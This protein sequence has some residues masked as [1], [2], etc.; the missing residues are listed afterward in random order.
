MTHL[1]IQQ[2]F[3]LMITGFVVAMTASFLFAWNA[4][5]PLQTQWSHYL[6]HVAKREDLLME[7]R[8]A[9]GYGGLIH[10]FKNYVLRA[11]EKYAQRAREHAGELRRLIKEYRALGDVSAQ[12]EAALNDLIAVMTAYIDQLGSIEKMVAEGQ[13]A[14]TIDKTVKVDD[15]PAFHAFDVLHQRYVALTEEGTHHVNESVNHI[16]V[17]LAWVLVPSGLMGVLIMLW[18]SRSIRTPLAQF[19]G[20]IEQVRETH[21]VSLRVN[22]STQDE[23]GRASDAFDHMLGEFG[24]IVDQVKHSA[25]GLAADIE[26]FSST[27]DDTRRAMDTQKQETEQIA[28]AMN[29]MA[30]TVQEVA[31]NA[32]TAAQAATDANEAS[33][34]G[35]NEVQQTVSTI[36][37]LAAGIA[38]AAAVIHRL[39]DDSEAIGGV[40]DVIKGIAEQTN[41]LALNAA[42][43]AARAGEQGRGFAVVA[44]EVRTLAQRTQESTAE[45]QGMIERLQ[46]GASEA[47]AVMSTSRDQAEASVT[48]ANNAGTAL[49]A[50][51]ES[52]SNISNMNAQ[53]ATA[54][55]EQSVVAEEMNQNVVRISHASEQ[56]AGSAALTADAAQRMVGEVETLTAS[57]SR[58]QTGGQQVDLEA[59]KARH[60]AWKTKMRSFLDGKSSMTA[61]QAM[62]HRDC[63]LGQWYYSAGIANYGDLKE[64]QDLEKPHEELHQVVK[65]IVQLKNTGDQVAAEREY[66]NI[67]PLSDRIVGLLEGIE[68]KLS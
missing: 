28:T 31:R 25:N 30:A 34:R 21:D 58:F 7:I 66:Q 53:I 20:V 26:Q 61:E 35:N 45:I 11:E 55:E 10:N 41:L 39:E 40:L 43:E 59:A 68:R 65:K 17:I 46:S 23:L 12:E 62:S 51:T 27:A 5:R 6:D 54:A 16:A 4:S 29:E 42:I 50:I 32:E 14:T 56:T 47:V 2:K 67:G 37:A 48:Q 22:A 18:V 19:S 15:W 38:Q 52:V 1:S 8:A 13:G 24:E 60:L 63:P 64:M 33:D 57:A 36:D 49:Q 44:D 3:L 9:F